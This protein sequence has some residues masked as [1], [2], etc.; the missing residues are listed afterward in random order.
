[1]EGVSTAFFSGNND[2]LLYDTLAVQKKEHEYS[3][4]LGKINST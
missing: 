2:A 3:E 4:H 1:M